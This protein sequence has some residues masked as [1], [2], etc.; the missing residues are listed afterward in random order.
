MN[1]IS[2]EREGGNTSYDSEQVGAKKHLF[3][4]LNVWMTRLHNSISYVAMLL[5]L[6]LELL[7]FMIHMQDSFVRVL[8]VKCLR[9]F[10]KH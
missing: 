1:E 8:V 10:K 7:T 4:F 2:E 9:K 3:S 6:V 5:L